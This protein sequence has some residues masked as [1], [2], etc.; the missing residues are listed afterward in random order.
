MRRIAL[1]DPSITSE[2][3][4][5]QIISEASQSVLD[6]L[7]PD[8]FFVRLTTHEF[9]LWESYRIM[10]GCDHV[11]VCG[12]NLLKSKMLRRNQWKISPFDFFF[13]KECILLGCGWWFYQP[14]PKGYSA[15]MLKKILSRKYLHS[16]RDDYSRQQLSATQIGNVANTACVTMWRLSAP[17]CAAIPYEKAPIALV[18]VTGYKQD[19][20]AD[21]QLINLLLRNYEKLYLW[22]QQPEDHDYARLITAGRVEFINP[23]LKAYTEFLKDNHVDYIGSRLHGG[24]RALQQGKRTLVLAVD[25]RATEICR[26]TGL[27]V[28][29]R[30]DIASI[31]RWINNPAP[32]VIRL[33]QAS[34]DAWRNQFTN[35]RP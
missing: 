29:E 12:S 7:F 9:H 6:E 4:G 2:N 23:N 34:I 16:V 11:F 10:N 24:I 26:D 32:T 20:A 22:V 13:R 14:P 27:P 28:V 1:L 33:P 30:T 31:E 25:N 5:D 15:A 35:T 19:P 21:T 18:T 8:A 17:H 3:T